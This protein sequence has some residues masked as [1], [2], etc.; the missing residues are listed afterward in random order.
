MP[1]PVDMKL[2]NKV[3]ASVYKKIPKH[4]GSPVFEPA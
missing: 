2:Y 1:E 3:K 4:R